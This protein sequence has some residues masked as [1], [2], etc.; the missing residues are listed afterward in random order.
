VLDRTAEIAPAVA[1]PRSGDA[2]WRVARRWLRRFF[3]PSVATWRFL[4]AQGSSSLT[5]RI[6]VLNVTGLL[7]LVLSILYLSQFRASLI[8]ARVQSLLVQGEII[9]GAIAASATVETDTITI[10]PDKLLELQTGESYG[11][12]DESLSA[13]EFPIN[14]ERVAPLLRRLVLPTRTQA[15]IYD[16]EGALLLDTRNLYGRGDVLRFDLIPVDDRPSRMERAWIAIKNWFGRVN[17]P[18]YRDLGPASGRGYP[19]VVQALNG[20]KSPKAARSTRRSR[21]S[22]SRC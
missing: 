22:G 17:L 20:L 9:A 15:R 10:D 5:R 18:V 13:L 8:D 2:R 11:P 19:E 14:P 7:A 12:I 3:A 6:V 21:P 1:E 4:V 16:R